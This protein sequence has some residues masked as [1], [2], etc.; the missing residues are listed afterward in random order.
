[1]MK[2][3]AV[4]V[5]IGCLLL[6]G[7]LIACDSDDDSNSGSEPE[8]TTT[9]SVVWPRG[10]SSVEPVSQ[11]ARLDSLEGKTI[12]MLAIGAFRTDESMPVLETALAEKYP[13]ATIVPHTEFPTYVPS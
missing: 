10:N 3:K 1:M 12:C 9:Y 7:F 8:V 11:A 2:L 5:G 13:T 4:L 6:I